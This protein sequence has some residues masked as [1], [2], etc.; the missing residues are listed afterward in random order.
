VKT[1]P[2]FF[3]LTWL[4]MAT[5]LQA[6]LSLAGIFTDQAVLQREVPVPVWGWADPGAEIVLEFAGQQ[7]TAIAGNDGKWMARL[8]AMAVSYTHLTLPTT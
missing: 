2:S 8:A 1:I 5:R 4:V 6:A 3:L 7:V